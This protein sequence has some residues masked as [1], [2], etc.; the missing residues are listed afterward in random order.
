MHHGLDPLDPAQQPRPV[1]VTLEVAKARLSQC[2]VGLQEDW[3]GT[4]RMLRHWAPWLV[5]EDRMRENTGKWE[6][7]RADELKPELLQVILDHNQCDVELYRYAR[8]LFAR[9]HHL[10][11]GTTT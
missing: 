3:P 7:E 6:A 8:R 5:I 2:V 11:M 4:K 9:Q 1:N 10:L